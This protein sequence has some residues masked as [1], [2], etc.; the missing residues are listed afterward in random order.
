MFRVKFTETK[1]SGQTSSW[2]F[3]E[4]T[5][6]QLKATLLQMWRNE[7]NN[8]DYLSIDK[9]DKRQNFGLICFN[10]CRFLEQNCQNANFEITEN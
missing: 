6:K 2:E 8:G 3:S 10:Y 1:H 9:C 5:K 4:I 7:I